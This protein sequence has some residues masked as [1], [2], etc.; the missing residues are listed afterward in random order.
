M[1]INT[2]LVYCF[3]LISSFCV[4][5]QDKAKKE[6]PEKVFTKSYGITTATNTSLFGGVTY[7]ITKSARSKIFGKGTNHYLN[8]ELVNLKHPKEK[9]MNTVTSSRLTYG[10]INYFFVLRPEYGREVILFKRKDGEGLGMNGIIAIG[11]SIGIQKPYYI[12]WDDGVRDTDNQSVPFD[13][14]SYADDNRI[15]GADNVYKGLFESK[16]NMGLH[17]KT[18]LSLDIST[19]RENASGVEL[20][21]IT[22]LF[23]KRPEIMAYSKS[24]SFSISSY[25]TLYFGSKKTK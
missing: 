22:E 24:P 13:P 10:K 9:S 23:S 8:A 12:I 6:K 1:K 18:A 5:A 3:C 16:F 25:L 15:L 7:R 11:P 20:G 14:V 2:R 21:F 4:L 19:F 17:L